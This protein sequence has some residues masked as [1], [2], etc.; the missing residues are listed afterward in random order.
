MG[1][2]PD[3][4]AVK[5]QKAPVRSRRKPTEEAATAVVEESGLKPPAWLKGEALEIWRRRGPGLRAARLLQA[6]DELVFARYCRNFALWLELRKKLD[7]EGYTYESE[8]AHGKLRRADPAFLIADRVER[9]LLAVEDRFGMNPAE[10]QRIFL[11]RASGKASGDLFDPAQASSG[12]SGQTPASP[13][14]AAAAS[15]PAKP[16]GFLVAGKVH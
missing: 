6:A 1:R 10:R 2:R 9:Q 16:A 7:A 13:A 3:P 14:A 4:A 15:K 8:S 12:P 11:A 5:A